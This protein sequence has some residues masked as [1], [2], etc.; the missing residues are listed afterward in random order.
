M[1]SS[2]HTDGPFQTV[3]TTTVQ[4][5][6]TIGVLGV[7]REAH[8]LVLF[9]HGSGSGRFSPRNTHV[10]H[11]LH[12]AGLATLLV[13]LLRNNEDQDRRKVFDIPL[14]AARLA[15]ATQWV[16]QAAHLA[17]LPICYFGASTGAAAALLAASTDTAR[18]AAIVSRGGRPDLAGA[19]ALAR[20]QSPTLLIVGG[21]DDDVLALN[22]AALRAMQ[23]ERDL[24]IVPGATH[25]FEEPGTL[26]QVVDHATRWFL[27]HVREPP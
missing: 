26:D 27:A 11:A 15:G 2:C 24:V 12:R 8:G 23:C 18:I 21:R 22:R 19:T 1:K 3:E 25:L 5:G 13:D 10:A 16:R 20:V 17:A 7:P 9:A 4:A 14:L 6:E